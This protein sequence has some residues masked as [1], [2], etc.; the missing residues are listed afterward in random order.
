MSR[1]TLRK[2]KRRKRNQKSK[3]KRKSWLQ[4]HMDSPITNRFTRIT[5]YCLL[6]FEFVFV[7]WWLQS[8]L[9]EWEEIA[10]KLQMIFS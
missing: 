6:I 3:S 1:K 9:L 8:L 2:I 5:T 7:L 10:T 4:K